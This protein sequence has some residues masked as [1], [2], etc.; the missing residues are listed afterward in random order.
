MA[1]K[2]NPKLLDLY[3]QTIIEQ[4]REEFVGIEKKKVS[5]QL[6]IQQAQSKKKKGE[7]FSQKELDALLDIRKRIG[8][9]RKNN[10][11]GI[12]AFLQNP[13]EIYKIVIEKI[14]KNQLTGAE[15]SKAVK[16]FQG[17]SSRTTGI[18]HDYDPKIG[19]YGKVGH[20]AVPLTALT[21]ALEDWV[22]PFDGKEGYKWLQRFQD[23]AKK[24]N[25]PI[26][27]SLLNFMDPAAHKPY[28]KTIQGI[29]AKRFGLNPKDI[30]ED[31]YK[32]LQKHQAHAQLYGGTSGKKMPVVPGL[33][34]VSPEEFYKAAK[35]WIELPYMGNK[36]ATALE[37]VLM[38]SEEM[39]DKQL[40]KAVKALPEIPGS[41]ELSEQLSMYTKPEAKG[42]LR[43]VDGNVTA[44][45]PIE[46]PIHKGDLIRRQSLGIKNA[47]IGKTLE[48]KAV[49]LGLA[50][51]NQQSAAH[52]GNIH[53]RVVEGEDKGTVLREEVPGILSGVGKDYA[54]STAFATGA[55][56]ANPTLIKGAGA[57]LGGP[58]GWA[59][60]AYGL[61]NVSDTYLKHATG[62]GLNQRI[63]EDTGYA[64]LLKLERQVDDKGKVT[65]EKNAEAKAAKQKLFDV[66]RARQ[67]K[68]NTEL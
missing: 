50:G 68:S 61:Y 57:V 30:P 32:E 66:L 4:L 14:V 53:R 59:A 1:P 67:E 9:E 18:G 22:Q 49:R 20:A 29:L 63:I 17:R 26:G 34:G 41:R 38:A 52:A 19:K 6:A 36:D 16:S 25:T 42:R 58:V 56:M 21:D 48:G 3:N 31:F 40:F 51:L 27:D 64:N 37:K 54:W 11:R 65:Y 2:Y 46:G 7:P 10:R 33:Q 13:P 45:S 43:L 5:N 39:T 60:G 23:L 62:K 8:R 47:V 35:P 55:A 24:N 28:G 44:S 12:G 15:L